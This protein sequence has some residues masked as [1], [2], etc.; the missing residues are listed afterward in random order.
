MKSG[1]TGVAQTAYNGAYYVPTHVNPLPPPRARR[2]YSCFC[3][4]LMFLGFLIVLAGIAVLIFWLVVK[5]H[6]P[7]VYA[8]DGSASLSNHSASDVG[9]RI[10]LRMSFRNPSKR[11]G[12]QYDWF[13]GNAYYE[14]FRTAG[15]NT[16]DGF[17]QS[18]KNTTTV[19]FVFDS[20]EISFSSREKTL[21]SS[22]SSKGFL[23]PVDVYIRS[24]I[25]M[26][27]AGIKGRR[28]TLKVLCDSLSI[29]FNS[30]SSFTSKR[31]DVDLDR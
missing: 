19:D 15:L 8:V 20:D 30:S 13:F 1:G 12:Y 2:E 3:R 22:A 17:Y 4:V 23:S 18:H 11:M 14:E 9:V 24:R 27:V 16:L 29:P 10:K 25:R 6:A 28:I 5:P 26:K 31:C 7:K 21:L